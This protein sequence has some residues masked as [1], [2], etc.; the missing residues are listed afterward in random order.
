M[1]SFFVEAF[2]FGC[3][4]LFGASFF[5]EP[6]SFFACLFALFLEFHEPV[7][8]D[9]DFGDAEVVVRG[10][11]AHL[12]HRPELRDGV[13]G[14]GEALLGGDDIPRSQR[15]NAVVGFCVVGAQHEFAVVADHLAAFGETVVVGEHVAGEDGATISDGRLDLRLE[16]VETG[17]ESDRVLE[18]V[19]VAVDADF[20]EHPCVL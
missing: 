20:L 2:A 1:V 6:V 11:D 4:L 9:L 19:V 18:W 7:A 17:T 8:G 13:D 10:V 5:A 3:E 14:G 12:H 15:S 16:I